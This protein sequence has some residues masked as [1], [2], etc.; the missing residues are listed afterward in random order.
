M[1]FIFSADAL[2]NILQMT[3]ENFIYLQIKRNLNVIKLRLMISFPATMYNFFINW[4]IK[5]V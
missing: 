5:Q 1:Y 2:N 3:I 4:Q